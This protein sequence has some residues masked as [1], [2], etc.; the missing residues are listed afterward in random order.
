[1]SCDSTV[2]LAYL[3]VSFASSEPRHAYLH[4]SCHLIYKVCAAGTGRFACPSTSGSKGHEL[5]S[6]LLLASQAGCARGH[7]GHADSCCSEQ[8]TQRGNECPTNRTSAD[9]TLAAA[10]Q[11]G[12]HVFRLRFMLTLTCRA[13]RWLLYKG[14]KLTAESV[15]A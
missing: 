10:G 9:A 3:C 4:T 14:H 11:Q 5:D 13:V 7:A 2:T 6:P 1:M 8:H 12:K 15:L